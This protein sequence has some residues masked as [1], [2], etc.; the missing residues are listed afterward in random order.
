MEN[1]QY[2]DFWAFLRLLADN[3]L[4]KHVVVIGSWA[5]YL[6]AQAGVL[7][8][9]EA[10]L[11]TLDID[12]LVRNLRRPVPQANIAALAREAGYI[13]EQDIL[14]ETT[15]IYTPGFM[16]IEFLILQQGAGDTQTLKT[17]LGVNAQALR[18]LSVLKEFT[19][20]VHLFE[21]DIHIPQPEAYVL[22]KIAIN[23]QRNKKAEK[24]RAA[25]LNLLPHL[26]RTAF[27][28]VYE[29]MTKKEQAAVRDFLEQ[30]NGLDFLS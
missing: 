20:T 11:R 18:H 16:E 6:Y 1:A 17:N 14:T 25:V 29:Y 24:D 10:N 12:F 28:R 15:K 21:M 3:D 23:E 5:E 13:V 2:K 22:H 8:D 19:I 27:M 26:E 9:F 4:L 7:P 30:N